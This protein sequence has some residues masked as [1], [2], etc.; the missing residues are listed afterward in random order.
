MKVFCVL[1]CLAVATAAPIDEFLKYALKHPN[2]DADNPEYENDSGCEVLGEEDLEMDPLNAVPDRNRRW[3]NNELFYTIRTS[4]FSSTEVALINAGIDDLV[5]SVRVNGQNCITLTPRSSQRDYVS[6]YKG[7]GCSSYV[8]RRGGSQS[9]SLA[10]GCVTRHGTIMHEFLHALGFHH[11]QKRADRD[12]WVLIN[13]DNIRAGTENNFAKLVE[14]VSIDHLG[15]PYDYGSVMHYGAYAFAVDRNIPTII[16]L[17]EGA[18]IGQRLVL[19]AMDIERVQI[20]YE[21][22]SAADS[23]YF[24]HLAGKGF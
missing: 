9:L 6:V 3:P 12:N 7:S 10:S 18:E 19:S 2:T 24:K 22:I 5:D 16:T 13:Y 21:C 17:E 20:Y 8:G 11:E 23:K 14:G 4:D 15:T 1:L